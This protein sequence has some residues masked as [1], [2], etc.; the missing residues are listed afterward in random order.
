M[1]ITTKANWIWEGN[2]LVLTHWEGFR[3]KGEY[4]HCGGGHTDP[5]A[6]QQEQSQVNFNNQMSSIFQSQYQNQTAILNFLKGKLE[7]M[8]N[9]PQGYDNATL[10]AMRTGATDTI[11]TQ[12]KNAQGALNNEESQKNGGSDLSSGTSA[13][14]DA[15]L[16]NAESQDKAQAQNT[17]TLNDAN[18]KQSNLWNAMNVLSGNVAS[19]FNPLGYAG[20]YNQGSGEVSSLSQA[21]TARIMATKNP[22]VQSFESSLGSGLGSMLTGGDSSGS[23]GMSGFLGFS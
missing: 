16:L 17:I 7:P 21:N 12:Y 9:N 19:Q 5:I 8:I 3:Y 6:Q 23:G 18:L 11:S 1:Y 20:A 13:Q 2:K 10:T 4:S 22:F 15:A 14:L